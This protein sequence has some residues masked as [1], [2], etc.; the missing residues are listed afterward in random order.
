MLYKPDAPK[1]MDSVASLHFKGS[2]DNKYQV[3]KK[4]ISI[5][6]P[7]LLYLL[8]NHKETGKSKLKGVPQ[9]K[10]LGW[11]PQKCHFYEGQ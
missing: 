2:K 1:N 9:Y 11:N 5:F 10:W 8:S 3:I 6:L 7:K 4:M